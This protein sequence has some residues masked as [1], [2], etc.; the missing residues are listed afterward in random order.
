MCE[1]H[2][3]RYQCLRYYSAIG[4]TIPLEEQSRCTEFGLIST[5][6]WLHECSGTGL[7]PMI[8]ERMSGLGNG[9]AHDYTTRY[10]SHPNELI[11]LQLLACNFADILM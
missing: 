4:A 2:D 3:M 6:D 11:H 9:S 8:S 7:R 10:P 1:L 5:N